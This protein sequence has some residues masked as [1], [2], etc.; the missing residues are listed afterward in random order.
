VSIY[1]FD[2]VLALAL[3]WSLIFLGGLPMRLL[4]IEFF[5]RQIGLAGVAW[6]LVA[7]LSPGS[8]LH[9]DI[10]IGLLCLLAWWRWHGDH[11]LSGRF[12]LSIASGLGISLGT[13]LTLAVTPG[14]YPG[15]TGLAG[16]ILFLAGVYLGGAVIGLAYILYV[17]TRRPATLADVPVELV[18]G[19]GRLLLL[20]TLARTGVELLRPANSFWV[21]AMPAKVR[22]ILAATLIILTL[23]LLA[24][25]AWRRIRSPSPSSSE[26]PLLALCVLGIGAEILAKL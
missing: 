25:W 5:Y 13:V 7:A 15:G 19:Y 10:F 24:W 21:M 14:A 2:L 17:F 11:G 23:P 1:P 20:L 22:L 18:Q 3:G 9:F 12:W 6:M 4:R 16:Q 26:A 8:I